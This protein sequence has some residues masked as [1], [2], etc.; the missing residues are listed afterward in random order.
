MHT[1]VCVG[2][3]LCLCRLAVSLSVCLW[4]YEVQSVCEHAE[5]HLMRRC[6]L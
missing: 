6:V 1:F 3:C 2:E 5:L 4:G